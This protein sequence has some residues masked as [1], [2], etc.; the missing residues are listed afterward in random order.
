MSYYAYPIV[1]QVVAFVAFLTFLASCWG[2]FLLLKRARSKASAWWAAR[3]SA[4]EIAETPEDDGEAYCTDPPGEP[5]LAEV[6]EADDFA[7]WEHEL[8]SRP[9]IG[10]YMRRMD[11]WSR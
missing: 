5:T 7:E 3:R 2:V 11:R 6:F 9:R 1:A 4:G 10:Q 8:A